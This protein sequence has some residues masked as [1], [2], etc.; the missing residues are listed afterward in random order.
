MPEILDKNASDQVTGLSCDKFEDILDDGNDVA[1]P[2]T[3]SE[4]A[5]G[6]RLSDASLL[7]EPLV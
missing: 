7:V 6:D 5:T 4:I 2:A 1:E 3:G